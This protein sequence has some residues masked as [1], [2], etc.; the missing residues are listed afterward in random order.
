MAFPDSVLI[1]DGDHDTLVAFIEMLA[2]SLHLRR[3]ITRMVAGESRKALPAVAAAGPL[4]R[5]ARRSRRLGLL[6]GNYF[7]RAPLDCSDRTTGQ[8]T[9]YIN[10][11]RSRRYN[12]ESSIKC[13]GAA[14]GQ[15]PWRE[16]PNSLNRTRFHSRE[17]GI[18]KDRDLRKAF[19]LSCAGCLFEF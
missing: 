14:S 4:D 6:D 15:A 1:V 11:I 8:I 9:C 10:R 18:S 17:L 16:A 2:Y 12:N 7:R 13:N 19:W 5:L 3:G